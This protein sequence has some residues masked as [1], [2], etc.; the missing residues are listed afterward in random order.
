MNIFVFRKNAQQ[1]ESSTV[2]DFNQVGRMTHSID[3]SQHISPANS[4]ITK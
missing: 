2:E 4:V 1:R 3:T